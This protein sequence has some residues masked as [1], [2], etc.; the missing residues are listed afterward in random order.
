MAYFHQSIHND[1][2]IKIWFIHK[3]FA[4]IRDSKESN[5][6]TLGASTNFAG[7]AFSWKLSFNNFVI[8]NLF[9]GHQFSTNTFHKANSKI[10]VFLIANIF[11][12][13]QLFDGFDKIILLKS[14]FSILHFFAVLC[15]KTQGFDKMDGFDKIIILKIT[16]KREFSVSRFFAVLFNKIGLLMWI[17]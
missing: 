4:V 13:F 10:C 11:V 6:H 3:S 15:N 12:V 17:Y 1:S 9:F 16:R 7:F 5:V 2:V 8:L 14:D